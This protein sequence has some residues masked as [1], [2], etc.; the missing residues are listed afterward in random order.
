MASVHGQGK[1]ELDENS[2]QEDD[3]SRFGGP[4][5]WL[6]C[7]PWRQQLCVLSFVF[8]SNSLRFNVKQKCSKARSR[9]E[10]HDSAD[11]EEDDM[12]KVIDLEGGETDDRKDTKNPPEVE[13]AVREAVFWSGTAYGKLRLHLTMFLC[14]LWD[15]PVFLSILGGSVSY[16][17]YLFQTDFPVCV[18]EGPVTY[19]RDKRTSDLDLFKSTGQVWIELSCHHRFLPGRTG[20]SGHTY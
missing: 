11:C 3:H 17:V 8:W 6:T 18:P 4:L 15:L 2:A 19:L 20:T 10:G 14:V 9:Q 16:P 7:D 12:D 1:N 5:T 13:R